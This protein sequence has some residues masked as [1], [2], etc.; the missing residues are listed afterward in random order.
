[1]FVEPAKTLLKL[2]H[3]QLITKDKLLLL[4][5]IIACLRTFPHPINYKGQAIIVIIY[6]CL[7]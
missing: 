7:S 3:T 5:F 4:L 6:Y 1:M 2:F